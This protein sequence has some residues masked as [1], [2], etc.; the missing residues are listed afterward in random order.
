MVRSYRELRARRKRERR[1][2]REREQRLRREREQR[3][4]REPSSQEK[5]RNGDERRRQ[6][7]QGSPRLLVPRGSTTRL[8]PPTRRGTLKLI[9]SPA[10][11]VVISR[12]VSTCA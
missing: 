4:R 2:R 10:G 1:S 3:L 11:H 12:Y 8:T 7:G 5:R 6:V 9:S